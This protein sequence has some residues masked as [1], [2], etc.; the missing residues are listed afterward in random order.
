MK[1]LKN[2]CSYS[3]KTNLASR[4]TVRA[5]LRLLGAFSI[6]FNPGYDWPYLKASEKE[7]VTFSSYSPVTLKMLDELPEKEWRAY[8]AIIELE[9]KVENLNGRFVRISDL[10]DKLELES[11]NHFWQKERKY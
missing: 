8:S 5:K 7:T 4:E 6:N 11:H 10:L 3:L 1:L 9:R 2:Y